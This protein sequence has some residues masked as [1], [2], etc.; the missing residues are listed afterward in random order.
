MNK[1]IIFGTHGYIYQYIWDILL[2]VQYMECMNNDYNE[3]KDIIP[4]SIVPF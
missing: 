3:W 4:P 1:M 2:S